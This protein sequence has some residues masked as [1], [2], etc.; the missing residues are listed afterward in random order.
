MSDKHTAGPLRIRVPAEHF[1]IYIEA[2][3]GR[4]QG[5]AQG[6]CLGYPKW[7]TLA[8]VLSKVT[9][10]DIQ[11][12]NA[13]RFVACWNACEGIN[14]EAVPEL[15]RMGESAAGMLR[16]FEAF[17][18]VEPDEEA[19]Y[20]C[21]F[22]RGS[23]LHKRILET[24]SQTESIIAKAYKDEFFTKLKELDEL[25]DDANTKVEKPEPVTT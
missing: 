12:A 17:A 18:G 5:W 9:D 13:E 15:L 19:G 3:L 10:R 2:D 11:L 1:E 16:M 25:V 6:N 22:S 20:R 8:V 23:P 24:I 21:V 14:P 7:T 4:G